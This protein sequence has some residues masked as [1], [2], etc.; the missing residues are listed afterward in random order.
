M[1][2]DIMLLA[3]V[4][5]LLAFLAFAK[6]TEW[7]QVRHEKWMKAEQAKWLAWLESGGRIPPPNQEL[8]DFLE[9]EGSPTGR[10]N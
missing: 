6:L 3:S 4:W 8:V 5:F 1:F 10:M 2:M 7:K 9:R